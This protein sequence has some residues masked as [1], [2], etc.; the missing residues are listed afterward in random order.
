M[1]AA[2]GILALVGGVVSAAQNYNQG[3][4]AN[5]QAKNQ[6]AI[7]QF[8]SDERGR[9]GTQ[10][11]NRYTRQVKQILGRQRA[12]IGPSNLQEAGSPLA[13]EEDTAAIGAEDALN[14]AH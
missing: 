13:V 7:M 8:E 5:A 10:D 4:I 14:I 11:Y 12:A 2:A 6:A 9:A 3:E 1:A